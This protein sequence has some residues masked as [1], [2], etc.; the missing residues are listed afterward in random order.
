MWRMRAWWLF[1]ALLVAALAVVVLIAFATADPSKSFG[2]PAPRPSGATRPAAP[3]PYHTQG[4]GPF[5][6]PGSF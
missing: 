3:Y 4:G 2:G 1:I 6:L 5:N